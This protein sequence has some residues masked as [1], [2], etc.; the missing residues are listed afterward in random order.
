MVR[1]VSKGILC[2]WTNKTAKQKQIS[3]LR[4]LQQKKNVFMVRGAHKVPRKTIEK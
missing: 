4:Q 2:L 1:V 3:I